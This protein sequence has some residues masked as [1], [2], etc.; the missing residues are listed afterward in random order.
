[1][2]ILSKWPLAVRWLLL[3]YRRGQKHLIFSVMVALLFVRATSHAL[4]PFVP[5]VR[6][7]SGSSCGSS[8]ALNRMS[9]GIWAPGSG[10]QLLSPARSGSDV[11]EYSCLW[12]HY[13]RQH[14]LLFCLR[15]FNQCLG[16]PRKFQ[17]Q[18]TDKKQYTDFAS[19]VG[20]LSM[21]HCRR[22]TGK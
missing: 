22:E 2:E 7:P 6:S 13:H 5:F 19:F 10:P 15:A 16:G 12:P 4:W 20:V 9:R 14:Y 11:C 8:L 17:V 3:L 21:S 1:M 18:F